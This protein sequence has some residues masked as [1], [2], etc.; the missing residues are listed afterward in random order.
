MRTLRVFIEVEGRQTYV[1][2]ICGN[3]PEDAQ[4]SYAEEYRDRPEAVPVSL[5]LPFSE[6]IMKRSGLQRNFL[7]SKRS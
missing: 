7:K 4:F 5:I 1:G 2:E 6:D 3:T